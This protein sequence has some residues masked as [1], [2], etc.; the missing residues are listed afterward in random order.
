MSGV[1]AVVKSH[2]L[3]VPPALKDEVEAAVQAVGSSW[4]GERLWRGPSGEQVSGQEV[5]DHLAK[6]IARLERAGWRRKW[7]D[8]VEPGEPSP[9]DE[10]SESSSVRAVLRA[11]VWAL[12]EFAGSGGDRRL[13]LLSALA[14]GVDDDTWMVSSR[15]MDL[16]LATRLGVPRANVTS[17]S[18]RQGHTF[19][20]V[21][22]LAAVTAEVARR[23]GPKAGDR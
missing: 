6:T 1:S 8:D 2:G 13:T 19:D 23:T 16:V 17:W 12:K 14:D 7:L 4:W 5:A 10:L 15:L 21:R 3:V 22:D 11:A 9:V 20:E 18:E